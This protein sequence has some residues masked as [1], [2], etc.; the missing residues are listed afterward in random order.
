MDISIPHSHG[1]DSVALDV[2]SAG[3]WD[4]LQRIAVAFSLLGV[5]ENLA[6]VNLDKSSSSSCCEFVSVYKLL[7]LDEKKGIHVLRKNAMF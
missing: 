2:T 7:C 3:D 1:C 6:A 4:L 5:V